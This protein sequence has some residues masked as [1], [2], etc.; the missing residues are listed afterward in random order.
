MFSKGEN[1]FI[2][3]GY[4]FSGKVPIIA[5]A[6]IR[7]KDWRL[8]ERICGYDLPSFLCRTNS[9]DAEKRTVVLCAT[10]PLRTWQQIPAV[11][12]ASPFGI[13]DPGI[14]SSRQSYGLVWQIAC[15][16]ADKGYGVW[17][18]DVRKLWFGHRPNESAPSDYKSIM[19]SVLRREIES[20]APERVV[21]FGGEAA[22]AFSDLTYFDKTVTTVQHPSHWHK[23]S[24]YQKFIKHEEGRSEQDARFAA[25]VRWYLDRIM[26]G[27][28]Q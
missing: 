25:K 16:L 5:A 3:G 2:K 15:G 7:S 20:V 6:D 8:D 13:H 4:L 22:R 12:V 18:T 1:Q 14:R 23:R 26:K 21:A 10:D 24:E 9:K 11:T 27:E 28:R 17:L 19:E